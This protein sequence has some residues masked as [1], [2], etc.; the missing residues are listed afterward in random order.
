MIKQANCSW[1]PR[2][3]SRTRQP[4]R[5]TR[6]GCVNTA[7]NLSTNYHDLWRGGDG[8]RGIPG[9]RSGITSKSSPQ[10]RTRESSTAG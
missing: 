6:S 2:R 1:A 5:R 10:P 8:Y 7:G 4:C 3:D 9:P